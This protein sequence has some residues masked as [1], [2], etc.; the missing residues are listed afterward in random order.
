MPVMP[1]PPGTVIYPVRAGIPVIA[2]F[3]MPVGTTG[4][5]FVAQL[6]GISSAAGPSDFPQASR[7][8]SYLR[9]ATTLGRWG[10]PNGQFF[11]FIREAIKQTQADCAAFLGVTV[12]EVQ[13]WEAGTVEVPRIMWSSL[14]DEAC[15]IDHPRPALDDLRIAPDTRPRQIRIQPD[16][17]QVTEQIENQSPPC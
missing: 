13:A 6:Q 8:A 1:K 15:R 4:I 12:P 7:D 11:A 17:P 2:D 3:V 5:S 10:I 16:I 9:A 14:V